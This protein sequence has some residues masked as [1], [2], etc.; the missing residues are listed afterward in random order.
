[1][2]VT[3]DPVVHEAL[4]SMGI[5]G[6]IISVLLTVIVA[7]ATANV[8]Q[9]RHSNKVY[10]YRLQERDTMRDALSDSRRTMVDLL[11]GMQERN[12]ITEELSDVVKAHTAGFQSL[13]DKIEMQVAND[14]HMKNRTETV[15]S[16]ISEGIRTLTAAVADTKTAVVVATAEVKGALTAL[17]TPQRRGG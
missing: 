9:W 5:A 4:A 14:A 8:W 3:S 1:M 16:A 12:E 10:G 2:G 17:K 15:I 6:A 7:L 11:K 13:K